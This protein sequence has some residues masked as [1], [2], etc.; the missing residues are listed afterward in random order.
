MAVEEDTYKGYPVLKIEVGQRNGETEWLTVG[1]KKA[2]A[3]V[4]NFDAI[5]A[6]VDKHWKGPFKK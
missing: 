6:W 5:N 1:V 3:I 2:V 4:E